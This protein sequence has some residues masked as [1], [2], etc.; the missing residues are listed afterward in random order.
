[1]NNQKSERKKRKYNWERNFNILRQVQNEGIWVTAPH[2]TEIG[3]WIK[4]CRT[5]KL[6]LKD[7]H[8]K[9]LQEMCFEWNEKEWMR[10]QNDN[11]LPL[12]RKRVPVDLQNIPKPTSTV[13]AS[14][15]EP[16]C[17]IYI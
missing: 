17:P 9:R 14:K 15:C 1:M 11:N 8:F 13:D 2:N 10:K 3:D 12:I 7:E 16:M 4:Y 6:Q 5:R